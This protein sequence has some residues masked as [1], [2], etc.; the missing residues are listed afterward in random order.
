[1]HKTYLKQ[2]LEL[3]HIRR[4]FCAPNPSVGAIIVKNN[5]VIATGYHWGNGHPHAEIE[6][7]SKIGES[8][9]GA[10]LY[11]TLEPCCHTEKKTPP[12]TEAIIQAGIKQVYYGFCDPNP[13]VAG[14]GEEKLRVANIECQHISLPEIDQ[15]Y[16][17]YQHW[18]QTGKPFVTAKLAMS[19]DGKIAGTHGQRITI[20]GPTAQQFTHQQ[21]KYADAILTTAKTIQHDDPL[22]NVRLAGEEYKKPIYIL[23]RQLNTPL[24]AKIFTTALGVTIFH[25]KNIDP[26]KIK[27]YQARNVRCQNINMLPEALT[28]IGQD[29]IH[30]LWIEAG[31]KC[32]AAFAHER[33]LQRAFI[34]VAPK[35]LGTE[36]QSAFED[37]KDIFA[38]ARSHQWCNLG[39]DAMCKLEW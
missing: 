5:H 24:D 17:S 30:D 29:G 33:L 13:A 10:I 3:A 14:K 8:A 22:L 37:N 32:F 15:F 4:G 34:Y 9:Q 27:L 19:L 25:N 18:W 39:E 31:G 6:A 11:V 26:E 12:C 16:Q 1:M 20:T 23:D 28:I 35:W 38:S 21:R 2:A 36:A 7:L